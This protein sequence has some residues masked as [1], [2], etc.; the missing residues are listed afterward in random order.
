MVRSGGNGGIQI[1]RGVVAVTSSI[2]ESSR[3]RQCL[4]LLAAFEAAPD[5]TLSTAN[6]CIK[7][8]EQ[9]TTARLGDLRLE[10]NIVKRKEPGTK[11]WLYTLTG[12]KTAAE[13]AEERDRRAKHHLKLDAPPRQIKSLAEIAGKGGRIIVREGKCI[14]ATTSGAFYFPLAD[15]GGQ[16]ALVL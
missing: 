15:T 11:Y 10:W 2:P 7:G 13:A 1:R 9:S 14:F 16:L 12:R 5:K 3:K 8:V 6:I 4:L